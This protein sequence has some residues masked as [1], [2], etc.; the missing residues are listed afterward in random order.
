MFEKLAQLTP[1]EL[2]ELG[3]MDVSALDMVKLKAEAHRIVEDNA[4][5]Q[6]C[7]RE[8][9]ELQA[10][11]ALVRAETEEKQ[12]EVEPS[13]PVALLDATASAVT[14]AER[15]VSSG[16]RGAGSVAGALA[17]NP[18][19]A[20]GAAGLGFLMKGGG[21]GLMKAGILVACFY[22]LLKL[23]GSPESLALAGKMETAGR[24][25]LAKLTGGKPGPSVEMAD[26]V[27]AAPVIKQRRQGAENYIRRVSHAIG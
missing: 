11:F 12:R 13:A 9:E 25:L 1:E 5:I 15:A 8:R 23:N 3:S 22:M 24:G 4:T 18:K 10:L 21:G 20:I 7:G 27:T 6:L 17:D 26:K 14:N 19:L 2:R 16:L